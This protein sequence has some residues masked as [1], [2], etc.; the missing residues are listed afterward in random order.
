MYSF[1][2][3]VEMIRWFYGGNSA[4]QV[5]ALFSVKYPNRPIPSSTTV[6]RIVHKL[7]RTG[8][9]LNDCK[10]NSNRVPNLLQN[11]NTFNVLAS[12]VLN[13]NISLRQIAENTGVHY[14]RAQR[15][16]KKSKFR[17]YK[18]QCH[19]E[20]QEGDLERRSTFCF[21][22]MERCNDDRELLNNVL[23]TDESTFTLH[24]EPNVQ[25]CRIWATE[26]PHKVLQTRTQYPRKVNVWVGILGP[27]IV[28]PF[29][30]DENLTA[31]RYLQLL[32]E[33]V[34]PAVTE[35]ARENEEIWFQMDGCPAHNAHVVREFL[36]YSF[37]NHVIGPNSTILP[38]GLLTFHPMIFFYGDI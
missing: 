16:L 20:L 8:T 11:E 28:G 17:S 25:N 21:E 4:R 29:F 5:C 7:E 18:Y 9:L 24:N 32:E 22:M 37:D 15:I 3:K 30:L 6:D 38:L 19:Q 27:H 35:V 10:C 23:F 14:S 13:P 1:Q 2:E 34:A 33:D 26:N 36:N 12:V 31:E